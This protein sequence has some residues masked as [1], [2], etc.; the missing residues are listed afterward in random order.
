MSVPPLKP[1]HSDADLVK[2]KLDYF[3]K[4]STEEL[5]ASLQPG[6]EHALKARP[7]GTV[8]DGHH[9]I[10]VLIGRGANVDSLPREIIV[11]SESG[12]EC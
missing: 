10:A 1:I 9:R 6:Q 2:S 8:L 12:Q 3:E 5:K 11:K 7:D 4:L